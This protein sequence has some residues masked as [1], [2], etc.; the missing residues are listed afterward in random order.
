MVF[1]SKAAVITNVKTEGFSNG[2][3]WT[4]A[5]CGYLVGASTPRAHVGNCF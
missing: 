2:G 5:D 3:V 1:A 4:L